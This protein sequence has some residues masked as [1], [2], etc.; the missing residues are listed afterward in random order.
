MYVY[1]CVPTYVCIDGYMW[2]IRW[3]WS[4]Q[5]WNPEVCVT[6]KLEPLRSHSC[7]FPSLLLPRCLISG[8]IRNAARGGWGNTWETCAC[9][10]ACCRTPWSTT[11]WLWSCSEASMTS[12]GLEVRPDVERRKNLFSSI[13][14]E[15]AGNASFFSSRRPQIDG[16]QLVWLGEPPLPLHGQAWP[17]WEKWFSLANVF[18]KRFF[19]EKFESEIAQNISLPW[20]KQVLGLNWPAGGE[21]EQKYSFWTF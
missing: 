3:P 9:R 21:A 4:C 14:L 7:C 2:N 17:I 5:R 10:R 11:T 15:C 12:S 8:T 6:G 18:L 20:E 19:K 1:T 13:H 16:S